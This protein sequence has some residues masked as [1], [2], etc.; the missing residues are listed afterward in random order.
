MFFTLLVDL[1]SLECKVMRFDTEAVGR[2]FMVGHT[3]I[4]Y[5]PVHYF[6][7]GAPP[8]PTLSPPPA[9]KH[10]YIYMRSTQ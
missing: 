4:K 3:N 5:I 1:E 6:R 2:L 9:R 8:G 7:W 10:I